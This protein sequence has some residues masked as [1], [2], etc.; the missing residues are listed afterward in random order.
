MPP[1]RWMPNTTV[2]AICKRENKYLVVR[3][4]INNQ[5]VINQPAGHL[6]QNESLIDA[7]VRETLEE[8]GY[9]FTPTSLVSIYRYVSEDNSG[10]TFLRYTFI[11]EAGAR[12]STK[13]DAGIISADWLDYDELVAQRRFHRSPL[14]LQSI[15]DSL[16]GMAFPLDIFSA[17]Y[18]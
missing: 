9:Q 3:E 12:L 5:T 6:E 17:E 15:E 14:I 13:L 2:A 1:D 4:L 8:T 7:V 10:K 11:G 16:S 18:S